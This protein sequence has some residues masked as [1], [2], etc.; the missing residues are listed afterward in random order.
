MDR[1]RYLHDKVRGS[2][3]SLPNDSIYFQTTEARIDERKRVKI[4]SRMSPFG[5]EK[6]PRKP[7][8]TRHRI[9]CPKMGRELV[10]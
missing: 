7:R 1:A 3:Q 8:W 9:E 10:I 5:L 2:T 4:L 6:G